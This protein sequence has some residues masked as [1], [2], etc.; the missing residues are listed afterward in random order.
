MGMTMTKIYKTILF[1]VLVFSMTIPI[2]T[3]SNTVVAEVN[4]DHEDLITKDS[5][6]W[7]DKVHP[8]IEEYK[9]VELNAKQIRQDLANTNEFSFEFKGNSYGVD[10]YEFDLMAPDAKSFVRDTEG[11]LVEVENEDV[12]TY[13]GY[14]DGDKSN[15]VFMLVSEDDV[16][17][18]AKNDDSAINIEPL[19][20][21]DKDSQNTRHIIYEAK[22]TPSSNIKESVVPTM[23]QLILP[24]VEATNSY[25]MRAV[26]DCD[27]AFYSINTGNWQTRLLSLMG[28]ITTDYSSETSIGI[29]VEDLAC[30]TTNSIYT[31]DDHH[32][33][34]DAVKD[35]WNG[36]EPS[37]R[38]AVVLI[39][40]DDMDGTTIG[41]VDDAYDPPV[42]NVDEGSYA[43]V[44]V[45][46]DPDSS[47]GGSTQEEKQELMHEFGGHIMGATHA[48]ASSFTCGSDTC[49][50]IMKP[51]IDIESYSLRHMSFSTSNDGTIASN[52]GSYLESN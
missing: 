48:A 45:G 29:S 35:E 4:K 46:N 42:S 51:L 41:F 15:S 31:S 30:D 3:M 52:A 23:Q 16:V 36:E 19:R 10:V 34:W 6:Q 25:T 5:T 14:I 39:V 49:W 1:A 17:L 18:L 12:K 22:I 37:N 33:L 24:E 44:Q 9:E 27:S 28:G 32:D 11:N 8:S 38:H 21:Y 43:V 26:M 7:N 2:A 47:Y 13:Q 20:N 40:E 50:T